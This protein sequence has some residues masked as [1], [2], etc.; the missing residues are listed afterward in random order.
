[1][2]P[3]HID[4]CF[5]INGRRVEMAIPPSMLLIDLIRDD[6]SLKG[7]KPGCL[8]GECG[9]CTVLVNGDPINSCLYLAINVHEKEVTTIE[10][11]SPDSSDET[12]DPVQQAM[13]DYGAI[14]CGFCTPGMLM[15]I[16]AYQEF[17]ATNQIIPD[18]EDIKRSLAGNLCRCTGY[19]KIID[20]VESLFENK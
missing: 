13:I 19:T 11:L 18:R 10:G 8:E 17:C 3:N 6:L 20:A 4:I 2:E 12:S 15:A 14:Q 1:M 7:T 5:T 9:A 16:K